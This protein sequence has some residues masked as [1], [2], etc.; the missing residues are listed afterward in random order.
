MGFVHR[1]IETRSAAPLKTVKVRRYAADSSTC[2]LCVCFAVNDGPIETWI[3]E[4]G[5]PPPDIFVEAARNPDW[6]IVAHNDAFES[7]IEEH[8]LA[9]Q[10]GWPIVPIERHICTEAMALAAALPG[11]LATIAEILALP[12]RKDSEG[13]KLMLELSKPRKARKGEDKNIIHWVE[14]TPEKL[15]RLI[16]YC[17]NDV[18]VERTVFHHLSHLSP[19]E[20]KVWQIDAR[21]NARGFKVDLELATAA[22]KI[23]QAEQ[24]RINAEI[25]TLSGGAITT[26]HQ[27]DRIIKFANARGHKLQKLNKRAVATALAHGPDEETR[28]LLELRR[29]GGRASVEKLDALF[30]S[31]CEDGR[32]RSTLRYYGSHTGRWTGAGFQPQNLKKPSIKNIAAAIAA[33]RSGKLEN[34]QM[35]GDPISIIADILRAIIIAE[36]GSVF[37]A[38]DFSAVE[39]RVLAWEAKE[40][41]KLAAYREFDR[42]G[43]PKL[44]P[45]CVI[46]SRVLGREVTPADEADRE[47][48][49][50]QDLAFGFGGSVGAWRR[51]VPDDARSDNEIYTQ[52]VVPFR[53]MHPATIRFWGELYRAMLV[54]VRTRKPVRRDR[55]GCDFID[56]NLHLI[57]P[58]G[59]RLYYPQTRLSISK[60]GDSEIYFRTKTKGWKETGSW[61]GTMVENLV[62]AIARDLLAHALVNLDA[63][64]LEPILHVHDEI[65]IEIAQSCADR[66][67][68]QRLMTLPPAWATD[69][70]IA[71]KVRIGERYIKSDAPTVE[72]IVPAPATEAPAAINGAQVSAAKST[73]EIPQQA[74]PPITNKDATEEYIPLADLID[75][76][77]PPSGLIHCRFHDDSLPSLK[78]YDDHYH[79]FGCGAHGNAIDW[80]VEVEGL[81]RDEALEVLETWDPPPRPQATKAEDKNQTRALELWGQSK[82]I[83]ATLAARYLTEP[84]RIDLSALPA[85]IDDVLRFHPCCPFGPGTR[86]PCLIALMR[87]ALTDTPTGIHRIAL[88]P[89]VFTQPDHKVE[90]RMLG[91]AGVVKLW[92]SGLQLVVGE[93]LETVLAAATR[94]P[95]RGALLRPAWAVLSAPALSQFPLIP[96]VERLI[97][98]ADH[99]LNGKGQ[100]AAEACK[101][102]WRQDGRTGIVLL[103][104][105]P[106]TDFNDL[107]RERLECVA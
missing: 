80:L 30:A 27:R 61:H 87:D 50:T 22:R 86:H 106:G 91:H 98:L 5:K 41:W 25:C 97:I 37:E 89:A 39:S 34:V 40:T 24:N 47:R 29:E 82:P 33:V 6:R 43:D 73:I 93:G 12:V 70:P 85:G 95:Y 100:A 26:V 60:F 64:G 96:K 71:A 15:A 62:Q 68:F 83:A 10:F 77:I 55:F 36:C 102:Q 94:I 56:G 53:R 67:E 54:C 74:I 7:A 84:R 107:V 46:A 45:Y 101:Q 16:L 103:P 52:E 13:R 81:D 104:D 58:S 76:T 2:V 9:P 32:I 72:E 42:T 49:K 23:V 28:K 19:F 48:G 21:I 35:L 69:L 75:E 3:P 44:E 38:G 4:G 31:V 51:F 66:A 8:I 59:R 57:L 1:D 11:E 17:C 79:C 99:D 78:I 92:P 63:A 105:R 90:R 14:L 88:T 18:E 65:V 20:Q